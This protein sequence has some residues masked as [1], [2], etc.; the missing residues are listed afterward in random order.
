MSGRGV[1]LGASPSSLTFLTL[2]GGNF[3]ATQTVTVTNFGPGAI[4]GPITTSITNVTNGVIFEVQ[5]ATSTCPKTATGSLA[6]G[7]T[8]LIR[9]RFR[10]PTALTQGAGTLNITDTEPATVTVGLT[11]TRL[12]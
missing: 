7:A 8:C 6:Q 10:S 9:I 11:G 5:N 3:G 2:S 1:K 4:T 12:F